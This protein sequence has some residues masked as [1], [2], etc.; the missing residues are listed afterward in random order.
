MNAD[1]TAAHIFKEA[2]L[3]K[4][5]TQVEVAQKSG[6]HPNSYAKIERGYSLASPTSI[7][8]LIKTLDI[9]SSKIPFLLG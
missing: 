5:L 2:R 6:M 3:K 4:G 8:K 7:K 1:K 9:E